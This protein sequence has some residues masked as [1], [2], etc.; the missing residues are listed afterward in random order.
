MFRWKKLLLQRWQFHDDRQHWPFGNRTFHSTKKSIYRMRYEASDWRRLTESNPNIL[1]TWIKF[2]IHA[3]MVFFSFSSFLFGSKMILSISLFI[4]LLSICWYHVVVV[5]L[6]CH[7]FIFALPTFV[8]IKRK[9]KIIFFFFSFNASGHS[10]SI[11]FMCCNLSLRSVSISLCFC[12]F[13]SPQ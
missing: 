12:S 5:P 1:F 3:K 7:L 2:G 4:Y 11:L 8:I 9:R 13:F 10:A 6:K